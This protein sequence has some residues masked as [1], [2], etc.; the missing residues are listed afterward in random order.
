MWIEGV[1]FGRFMRHEACRFSVR[2]M[3]YIVV[4]A[5]FTQEYIWDY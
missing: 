1:A 2:D 5:R 3:L 4:C